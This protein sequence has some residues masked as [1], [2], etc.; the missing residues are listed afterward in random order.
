VFIN[1][2]FNSANAQVI[3]LPRLI[4]SMNGTS[5]NATSTS[6]DENSS[7]LPPSPLSSPPTVQHQP[8]E[9]N[10]LSNQPEGQ[11]NILPKAIHSINPCVSYDEE[12]GT[13]EIVCDTNIVDLYFGLR[14]DSI[15]EHQGPDQ[16]LIKSNITVGKD[17]TFTINADGGIR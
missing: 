11:H 15:L 7:S 13:I 16:L 8:S 3:E 17:A 12:S 14:D 9:G 2:S 10:G 6:S 5:S 1:A 4:P